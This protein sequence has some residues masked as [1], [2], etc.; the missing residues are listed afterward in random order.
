VIPGWCATH[1]D[2]WEAIV[3]TW[4]D[5]DWQKKHEEAR[6]RHLQMPGVPHHQ[7]SRSLSAFAKAY[8]RILHFS[9]LATLNL[10]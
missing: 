7:G 9:N 10:A 6:E 1:P 8:V 4:L 2:C 3:D 5:E